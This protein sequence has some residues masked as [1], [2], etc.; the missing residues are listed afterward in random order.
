MVYITFCNKGRLGNLIFQYLICKVFTIKFGH[1]Y[2]PEAEFL[3]KELHQKDIIIVNN[4][5]DVMKI[6]KLSVQLL[7]SNIDM[8]TTA[9]SLISSFFPLH[10]CN[11]K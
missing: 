4:K 8:S 1:E 6:I 9:F 3:V 7:E 2:I 10:C 11:A 5:N